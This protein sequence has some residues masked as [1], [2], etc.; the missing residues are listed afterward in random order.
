LVEQVNTT[1]FLSDSFDCVCDKYGSF[2]VYRKGKEDLV[3]PILG[4]AST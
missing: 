3:A 4:G 1:I 2:I